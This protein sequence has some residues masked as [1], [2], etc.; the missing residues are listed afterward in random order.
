MRFSP[1]IAVWALACVLFSTGMA[2]AAI[3]TIN[4]VPVSGAIAQEGHILVPFRA[5][6]EQLGAVVVWSDTE[7]RG[8][9]IFSGHELV[10]TTVGSSTAYIVGYP[11]VLTVAPVLIEPQHL[12]YVPVE[13]L[14][15]I[16]NAQLTLATDGSSAT[17]TGFDLAGVNAIGSGAASNDPGGKVLLVW[18]WLLPLSGILCLAA[19]V[20]VIRQLNESLAA[21]AARRGKPIK[22]LGL[23]V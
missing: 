1:L 13:M 22:P 19:Y 16:S 2:S 21:A 11:K 4:G 20:V 17:I 23:F 6:M 18:L 10:R 12:E 8:I 7:Q 14:P 9:A 15:Q 3:V 5:P